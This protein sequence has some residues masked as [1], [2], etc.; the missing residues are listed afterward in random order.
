MQCVVEDKT[1]DR[2]PFTSGMP[3]GSILGWL[4]FVIYID[5]CF[6]S[7]VLFADDT[8]CAKEISTP[9]VSLF[10]QQDLDQVLTGV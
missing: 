6:S 3:Q 2:L 4:L 8:K 10:L 7:V 5:V 1:S 9:L